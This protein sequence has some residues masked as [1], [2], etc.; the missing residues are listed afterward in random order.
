MLALLSTLWPALDSLSKP[1]FNRT[2]DILKKSTSSDFDIWVDRLICF[3]ILL[4][5]CLLLTRFLVAERCEAVPSFICANSLSFADLLE[6]QF[7]NQ[8]LYVAN[9]VDVVNCIQS[10]RHKTKS[11]L[12]KRLPFR[13]AD[14]FDMKLSTVFLSGSSLEFNKTVNAVGRCDPDDSKCE[15]L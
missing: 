15:V 7:A 6:C 2:A 14:L 9:Q 4:G 3:K 8:K 13:K 10:P 12:L 5:T 1:V 11:L